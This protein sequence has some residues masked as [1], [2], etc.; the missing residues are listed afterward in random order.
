MQKEWFV[1]GKVIPVM[2]QG[3]FL[4][5][6]VFLVFALPAGAAQQSKP[7]KGPRPVGAVNSSNGGVYE[8]GK[9]GIILKYINFKQDQLYDGN[10]E[11]DYTRPRRGQKPG[12]KCLERSMEKFQA[13]F[14]AGISDHFDARLIV[15]FLNKEMTRQS[16]NKEFTDS[17]S[18]I[19]DIKL[20]GRYRIWSQKGKDPFNLAVGAGVKIPT[21]TTDEED[22]SGLCLP[23]FLQTGTGSWDP[24]VE[25][26]AHKVIGR[27]WFS[28][29]YMYRMT[30]EGELGDRDFESPDVFKY[31]FAYAYALSNLFD[32]ELEL[33]GDVKSKAKLDGVKKENTGGHMVYLTPGVHFKFHKGMHFDVGM[34]IPVYRDLNG[35]QFS[36]DYRVVAKLALKF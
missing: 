17:H 14:R 3:L 15:P 29:Y 19:G 32:L 33:N 2:L 11:V 6:C 27:H 34:P 24:I 7:A 1:R 9:Y 12:K 22:D 4:M 18:G 30:T 23:G 21:G 36:E 25:L 5:L 16:F 28:T 31:N 13:T 8:K 10:D 20:I 35:I 26:G